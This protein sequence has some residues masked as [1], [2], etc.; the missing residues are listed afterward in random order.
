MLRLCLHTLSKIKT[1]IMYTLTPTNQGEARMVRIGMITGIWQY[2]AGIDLFG[3]QSTFEFIISFYPHSTP[4][5][6]AIIIIVAV[7][8]IIITVIIMQKWQFR[9]LRVGLSK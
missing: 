1:N 9:D 5:R 7:L 4:G 8:Y 3:L 6:Q 2:A